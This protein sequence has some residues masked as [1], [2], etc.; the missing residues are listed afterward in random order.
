MSRINL[1]LRTIDLQSLT[2]NLGLL[3]KIKT[4]RWFWIPVLTFGVTRLGIVLMAYLGAPLIN[5]HAET[6]YHLRPPENTILD[7]LGSRWDTGFYV[8]IAEEGYKFEGVLL[9]SV[10][11]FPLL[12]LL[13]RG[14][15]FLGVDTL[16]SGV[17]VANLALLV[18]TIFF[19]R[20]VDIEWGEKI[21]SRTIW[22]FLIFPT[23]FFGSAIYSESLFLMCAIGAL[24]FARQRKWVGAGI[25]GFFAA[26]SRF[27][28]LLV[29]P[30]LF[31]EWVIQYR[32]SP[33]KR[34][35]FW[36]VLSS[37]V[38]P[39]G[40]IVYMVF[41]WREFGDP[42]A[43]IHGSAAWGR[44]PSSPI[45]M[46]RELFSTPVGGWG[47]A[48]PAGFIHLDNWMDFLFV[49]AFLGMGLC[50]L[51]QRK[52]A[53]G[54]FVTVGAL[55]PLFSGLLMSQRRYMWVL[56]PVFILL[57][58]WGENTWV[59]R[60]LTV[61]FLTGLALFTVLFANGYWVA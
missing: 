18:A 32:Q 8:S 40:T 59:E 13:M 46:I 27:L 21:A 60:L 35:V 57:S 19:Y 5:D 56:F 34:P 37:A 30:L 17:L 11:F 49:V 24:F 25:L 45:M 41:L 54:V 51:V 7:V 2:F 53:E 10:P 23:S 52:I 36:S 28:G 31:L 44:E 43:F 50:L 12:P 4:A 15:M 33:E 26:S 1:N 58:R 47:A 16:F 14:F 3:E 29:A 22:Y 42:L 38:V 61:I 55:L 9:P 6:L 39:L 48:L 20:L